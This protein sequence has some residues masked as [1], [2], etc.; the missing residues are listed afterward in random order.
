VYTSAV[1]LGMCVAWKYRS[2][3]CYGHLGRCQ[4]K[5]VELSSRY[6]SGMGPGSVQGYRN[7]SLQCADR[8]WGHR[9]GIVAKG[10]SLAE[11]IP[12]GCQY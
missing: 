7:R 9:I 11:H 8:S 5:A 1:V 3:C 6:G 2:G 12:D 4:E 10:G